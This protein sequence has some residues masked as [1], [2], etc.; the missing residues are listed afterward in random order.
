MRDDNVEP[1]ACFQLIRLS[2]SYFQLS[3][4]H[5]FFPVDKNQ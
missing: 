2:A 4:D 1:T 3:I 5:S